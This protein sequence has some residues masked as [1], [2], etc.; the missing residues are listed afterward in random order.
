M[1]AAIRLALEE[2]QGD[3][4]FSV[5]ALFIS[6]SRNGYQYCTIGPYQCLEAL[7]LL[8]DNHTRDL[9]DMLRL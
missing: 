5:H 1:T 9:L 3:E 2:S 6:S 8:V 7:V 4:L